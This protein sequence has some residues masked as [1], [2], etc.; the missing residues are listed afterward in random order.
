MMHNTQ[1][2]VF[3]PTHIPALFEQVILLKDGMRKPI[4]AGETVLLKNRA[5]LLR[6][7]DLVNEETYVRAGKIAEDQ[8]R[9]KST[10][11]RQFIKLLEEGEVEAAP[12]DRSAPVWY[13]R[14]KRGT[15]NLLAERD[16]NPFFNVGK[17][18]KE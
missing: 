11:Y 10:I 9:S 14:T 1:R 18:E 4:L 17:E 6:L 16:S 13:K 3:P 2:Q 7:L 5:I 12:R 8:G 15:R